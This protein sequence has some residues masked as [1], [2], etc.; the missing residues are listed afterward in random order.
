MTPGIIRVLPTESSGSTRSV[1]DRS[2]PLR[3]VSMFV[4]NA[5]SCSCRRACEEEETPTTPTIAAMPM[6]IPRADRTARMGRERRPVRPRRPMSLARKLERAVREL[7]LLVMAYLPGAL[8][9]IQVVRHGW[10]SA[11]AETPPVRCRG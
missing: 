7:F 5:R 11:A 8:S 6:A 4:P 3:A 1:P 9:P 10:R 2:A